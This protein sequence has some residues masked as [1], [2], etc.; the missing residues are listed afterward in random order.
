MVVLTPWGTPALGVIC[1]LLETGDSALSKA[2]SHLQ[3]TG[4]LQVCKGYLANKPRTWVKA[5][6]AGADAFDAHI[7]ALREISYGNSRRQIWVLTKTLKTN[8][9]PGRGSRKVLSQNEPAED[10]TV[11]RGLVLFVASLGRIFIKHQIL[12][13]LIG[14]RTIAAELLVFLCAQFA[15]PVHRLI[16]SHGLRLG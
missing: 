6:M 14:E 4:Y 1:G 11:W 13:G 2:I 10:F 8:S 12:V 16:K 5:T 15:H 9:A 3:K 7:S